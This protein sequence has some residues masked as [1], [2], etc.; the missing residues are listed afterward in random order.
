MDKAKNRDGSSKKYLIAG[1][2]GAVLVLGI[3]AVVLQ[4]ATTIESGMTADAGLSPPVYIRA[5]SGGVA[6]MNLTVTNG[7]SGA[8]QVN[9]VN[10]T[11]TNVT[12]F[13][14][15]NLSSLTAGTD[16]GVALYNDTNGNGVWDAG[17]GLAE[18]TAIPTWTANDSDGDGAD[19]DWR[20]NF[21]NPGPS[22]MAE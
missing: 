6:V 4:A 12:W 5:S 2:I 13:D 3:L 20:V 11:F 18:Y 21:T 15:S 16:S 17:E 22:V 9:F 19:D 7:T 8:L 14:T 10:I 1:L